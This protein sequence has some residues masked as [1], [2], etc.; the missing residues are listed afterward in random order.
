MGDTRPVAGGEERQGPTEEA[1]GP[2]FPPEAVGL[3]MQPQA[4][5]DRRGKTAGGV[6]TWGLQLRLTTE[7]PLSPSAVWASVCPITGSDGVISLVLPGWTRT[8]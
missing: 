4:R 5:L 7:P 1:G 3:G 8:A 6:R 2:S